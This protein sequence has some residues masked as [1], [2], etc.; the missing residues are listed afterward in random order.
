MAGV[1]G[2]LAD[3]D[4]DSGSVPDGTVDGE[5]FVGFEVNGWH[6]VVHVVSGLV[7]LAGANTRLSARVAAGGFGL[8]YALVALIGLVDGSD[9]IGV[10]PVN[11]A[12]NILHLVLAALGLFTGFRSHERKALHG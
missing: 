9:V 12:D 10:V 11:G 1:L 7:L 4:F 2:F 5:T 8:L 3:A 6:N